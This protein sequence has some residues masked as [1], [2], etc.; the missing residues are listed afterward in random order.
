MEAPR[1]QTLNCTEQFISTK[2]YPKGDVKCFEEPEDILGYDW[3]RCYRSPNKHYDNYFIVTGG[4]SL[5]YN[6]LTAI[7]TLALLT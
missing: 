2:I 3:N 1:Y 5:T 6:I 4:S 7:F